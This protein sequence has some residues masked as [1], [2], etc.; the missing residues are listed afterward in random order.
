MVQLNNEWRS[1]FDDY[2]KNVITTHQSTVKPLLNAI[3]YSLCD[4]GKRLRPRLLL[5]FYLLLS[6]NYKK[7]FPFAAALEMIHAS[8]LIHDDMPCMDDDSLRRGKPTL[9]CA[10]GESV[11]MVAGDALLNLAYETMLN[12]S[13]AETAIEAMRTIAS[14]AGANG[15]Q[16]GQYLDTEILTKDAELVLT[17]YTLK[18]ARLIEA[19]CLAGIQVAG[20]SAEE[21]RA[22]SEFGLKLGIAFQIQDDILDVVGDVNLTGKMTGNDEK[23]QKTT[24]LSLFGME[25]SKSVV[26]Q[27]LEEAKNALSIF[28]E[29]AKSL[30]ALADELVSRKM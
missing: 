19:A 3:E 9:H 17:T 22:A 27:L 8:S 20:G 25:T 24:Y 1:E 2:L 28:G 4:G 29:R 26:L 11:A 10:K 6:E 13:F 7:A 16:G 23:C 21:E 30:L 5:E 12:S 18:T 15:V 14:S